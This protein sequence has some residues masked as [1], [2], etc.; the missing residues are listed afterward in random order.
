MEQHTDSLAQQQW[1]DNMDATRQQSG[2]IFCAVLSE[3]QGFQ[4]VG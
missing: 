1:A 3:S 2:V 4:R